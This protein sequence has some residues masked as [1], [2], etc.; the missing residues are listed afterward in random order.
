MLGNGGTGGSPWLLDPRDEE[1]TDESEFLR[2]NDT[3]L[4]VGGVLFEC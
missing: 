2:S 3:D 1:D 4:L